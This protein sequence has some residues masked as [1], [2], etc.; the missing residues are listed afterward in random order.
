MMGVGGACLAL[1]GLRS[2]FQAPQI[3]AAASSVRLGQAWTFR[4]R[5]DL[6]PPSVEVTERAR[7]TAPG[8]L[9]AASKNGPGEEYPAQDGPM[10]LDNDGQPV[11]LCPVRGEEKD[12]MDFK[13][14]RYRGEPVLTWWEGVHTG[15]G[16]G[17]YLILDSSYQ[18]VDR[19][20]AGHGYDGDHH[21]FL[22]T[23]EDTAL[24]TIYHKAP[25]DL[26]SVGGPED[27]TVLDGIVQEVDIETGEVLFEWHSLEHVG[28]D[29]SELR[30]D[31]FH[32]NA[33]DVDHDSNLLISSRNTSA[34]YKVDRRTGKILWRLGGKSSDFEMGE[35]ARFAYQHDV[36]RC[37]NGTVT[38]FDNRDKK[39]NEQSRGITLKLDEDA[40]TAE[41]LREYTLP[42][43]PFAIFQGSVQTLP[44]GNVFVG[45]GS[46]PYLSEFGRDGELLFDAR[47]PPE[48]ESYRAFR[49]PWSGQPD[50]DPALAAE[51]GP[52]DEVTLYASWN[53]ATEVATWEVLAGPAPEELKSVGSAPRKGFETVIRVST[54]EPYLGVRAK[55]HLGRAL[56]ST[57]AIKRGT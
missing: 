39:M 8:Y 6:R 33:I 51:P 27:G 38:M 28:L 7:G 1:L 14:Q 2:C 21:E 10:I 32:V 19:V 34:V 25:M 22:I 18:E 42:E 16:L 53:G 54:G 55:D 56:G 36:R 30:Y 43:K 12:A 31:Y 35:G 52:D 26:S 17:E 20:R 48:V 11:W 3:R 23:P 13:V 37:P 47:F 57:R 4:S 44:D 29:E 50:V 46:A 40:M 45:W 49:F 24:F 15:Y 9:F 5:P 41:L